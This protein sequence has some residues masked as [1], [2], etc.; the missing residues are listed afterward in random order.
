MNLRND[1]T[2][3]FFFHFCHVLLLLHDH[4][5]LY[6]YERKVLC[7]NT[8]LFS[9][10][11]S[12]KIPERVW[13]FLWLKKKKKHK[14]QKQK[15]IWKLYSWFASKLLAFIYEVV[16]LNNTCVY[17]YLDSNSNTIIESIMKYL[18][19]NKIKSSNIL[20]VLCTK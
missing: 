16:P 11:M 13:Y 9:H 7:S 8:L 4:I 10:F 2:F 20:F 18:Q 3:F 6:R 14:K 12:S 19:L 1:T 17:I 15:K 5:F